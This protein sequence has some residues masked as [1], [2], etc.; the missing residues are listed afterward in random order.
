MVR[1]TKEDYYLHISEAVSE[2]S[3]C[4]RAHCGAIIVNK[5][6]ILST[7]YNGNPRGTVNCCD[8]G[9]CP[10]ASFKPQE[11]TEL[12]NAVHGEMNAL[13]NL[14]RH[15]GAST[16]GSTLFVWFK[17]LDTSINTYNKPCDNCMKHLINAGIK[18]IINYTEDQ[19][20]IC[21]DASEITDGVVTTERVSEKIK[22]ILVTT[23][24][25]TE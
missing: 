24:V 17:R 11:G 8:V 18:Y 13:M 6:G 7:G 10:R 23:P 5:D 2:R 3:T 1:P 19:D 16:I 15:G 25:T 14:C 9:T 21:I 12:C 4:L 20:K 22:E